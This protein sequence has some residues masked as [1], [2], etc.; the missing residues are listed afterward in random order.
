MTDPDATRTR[1]RAVFERFVTDPAEL[2]AAFAGAPI[3]DA[4]SV[5]SIT[6][7]HL[8]ATI[9]K[10]FAVRFDYRS[11]D[12]SFATVDSLLAFIGGRPGDGAE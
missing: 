10:E 12:E 11:M 7:V 4:V 9:E 6:L 3:L 8:V 2:D 5:D 1:L